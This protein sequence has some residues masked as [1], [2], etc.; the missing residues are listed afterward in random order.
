[1]FYANNSFGNRVYI[2]EAEEGEKYYCPLCKQELVLKRGTKVAHHFAHKNLKDCDNWS[3]GMTDWH[4]N[5]QQRFTVKNKDLAEVVIKEDGKRHRADIM[6]NNL[7]IEFQH[8]SISQTEYDERCDFY[9]KNGR[10]L[11]WVFD[12]R[13]RYAKGNI[14]KCRYGSEYSWLWPSKLN[15]I[16]D[17]V[18]VFFQLSDNLIVRYKSGGYKIKYYYFKADTFKSIDKFMN[19]MRLLAKQQKTKKAV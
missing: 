1:M 16:H 10:K 4:F 19:Y 8:S 7:V 5:W 17:N 2:L 11:I 3:E 14:Y 9:T 15:F 6:V 13:K 12:H 18:E